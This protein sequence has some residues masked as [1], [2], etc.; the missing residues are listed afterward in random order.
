VSTNPDVIETEV[1]AFHDAAAFDAWLD[2]HAGLPGGWLKMAKKGS[3]FP[4]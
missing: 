3:T 1:M 4:R 2:E